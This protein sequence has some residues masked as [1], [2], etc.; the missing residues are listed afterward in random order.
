MDTCSVAPKFYGIEQNDG[1]Y[2]LK[3]EYIPGN[4]LSE[5]F[6]RNIFKYRKNTRNFG[7]LHREINENEV[8]GLI[9]AKEKFETSLLQYEDIGKD[10]LKKLMLF[11]S[12]TDKKNLCYGELSLENVVVDD[13]GNMR[14]TDW[15]GAYCGDPLSDVAHAY[16]LLKHITPIGE[17]AT[18][19]L[20]A[21]MQT[22][23]FLGR[24]YLKSY[25][26]GKK[27]P[28][29]ELDMWGLIIRI[30]HY[31]IATEEEK[32]DLKKVISMGI[33]KLLEV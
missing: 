4:K 26:N 17:G 6:G 15:E 9:T 2:I 10:S 3:L 33:E 5:S 24:V 23:Q 22:R 13:K 27:V 25:F 18:K 31:S 32:Q 12:D 19:I 28:I 16:Y 30:Y 8:S 1:K 7:R 20:K 11:I 21:D 14:V 29:R